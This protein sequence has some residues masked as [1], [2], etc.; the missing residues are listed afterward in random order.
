MPTSYARS[1]LFICTRYTLL[2]EIIYIYLLPSTGS[3]LPTR[4][5][6]PNHQNNSF[7][8]FHLGTAS[9]WLIHHAGQYLVGKGLRSV[10][11]C[12][13]FFDRNGLVIS[14]NLLTLP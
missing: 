9:T 14:A 1:N 3:T 2:Q 12:T 7:A 13:Y 5:L 4:G 11:Y 8:G 10:C 6:W